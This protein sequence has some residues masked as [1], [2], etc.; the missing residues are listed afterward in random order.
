MKFYKI[1]IVA[2]EFL[3]LFSIYLTNK[4][5]TIGHI[6]KWLVGSDLGGD[7]WNGLSYGIYFI[8]PILTT[9]V[10]TCSFRNLDVEYIS[11]ECV[12]EIESASSAFLPIFLAYVFVGLSVS[13]VA[14]LI[15]IYVAVTIFCFCAEIYLYNPIFH[16]LG[17]RFYFV[18]TKHNRL[19]IMTRKEIKRREVCDFKKIGR[20]NDF[21]YIDLEK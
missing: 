13:S 17:Y 7:L 21:T 14:A 4:E 16:I 1:I 15:A 2:N 6:W 12:S 20:I 10:V 8:V 19:L 9:L 5:I 3:L 11:K 18:K